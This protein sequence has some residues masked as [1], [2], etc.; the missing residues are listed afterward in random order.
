[1]TA[2]I[3]CEGLRKTYP[4][5]DETIVAVAGVSLSVMA[6]EFVAII[7]H[8]GSGKSTLLSMIGGMT[9]P[10]AGA[11]AVAGEDVWS[12]DDATRAALRNRTF[13]FVFQFASLI[14]TL[15]ARDNVV[16]PRLFG[17]GGVRADAYAKAEALLVRVGLADRLD[18]FP[19]ELSGGQQ[20][21]VAIAR[22]LINDPRLILADEPT[23]DL[24]E[25]SE[26]E[27]MAL[28]TESCREMGAGLLMVTHDRDIAARA[29][30]VHTMKHGVLS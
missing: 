7:G 6:G 11:V 24:D 25:D 22:A 19:G 18:N 2:V 10:S 15:T 27:V 16:L 26:R 17:P 9:R 30:R 21:R 12:G 4:I 20:R 23:G 3:A 29:A 28:L 1:M 5:G 8:S 14:P 13:G